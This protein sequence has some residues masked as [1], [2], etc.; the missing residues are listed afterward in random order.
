M[1]SDKAVPHCNWPQQGDTGTE[2]E[3][4]VTRM[5]NNE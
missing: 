2:V 1:I 3:L 4:I 5:E